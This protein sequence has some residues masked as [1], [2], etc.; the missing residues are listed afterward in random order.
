MLKALQ[1]LLKGDIMGTWKRKIVY[2]GGV[3]RY[4]QTLSDNII[5]GEKEHGR[6]NEYSNKD[7]KYNI[8]Y[9]YYRECLCQCLSI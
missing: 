6:K 9:R 8:M 5:R 3:V 2:R 4:P 1:K 7:Y